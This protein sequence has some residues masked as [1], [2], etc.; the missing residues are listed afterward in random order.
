[1]FPQC[2][3]NLGCLKGKFSG[4]DDDDT[5]NLVFLGIDPLEARNNKSGGLARSILCTGQDVSPC[6]GDRDTLLLDG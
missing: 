4:R 6:K 3:A 1:M 2:L 5:L